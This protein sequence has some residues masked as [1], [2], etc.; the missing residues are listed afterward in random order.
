MTAYGR[1]LADAA[2]RAPDQLVIAG[3][4]KGNPPCDIFEYGHVQGLVDRGALDLDPDQVGELFKFSIAYFAA[5]SHRYEIWT[6]P[7]LPA[8]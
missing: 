2:G 4:L 6:G 8:G 3:L 1:A 7:P 5:Q